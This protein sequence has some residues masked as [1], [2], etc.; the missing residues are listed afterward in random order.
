MFKYLIFMASLLS[1]SSLLAS[2]LESEIQNI[3]QLDEQSVLE[4]LNILKSRATSVLQSA[5]RVEKS[6]VVKKG[7]HPEVIIIKDS[8][9]FNGEKLKFGDALGDW[10]K[11]ISGNPRCFDGAMISCVW[12]DLGL[13]IGTDMGRNQRVKFI[14]IYFRMFEIYEGVGKLEGKVGEEPQEAA[15]WVPR[16]IFAGYLEM[17][18]Y[19]IDAET[20]FRDIRSNIDP[21]RNL[22]C[23]LRD[24][25]HPGGALSDDATIY[26]TLDGRSEHSKLKEFSIS[27]STLHE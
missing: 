21:K 10:K 12:D 20:K 13:E 9:Y 24:C 16:G 6:R 1:S 5:R 15:Y 11:I 2:A 7:A 4:S 22:N 23:G 17:D 3:K 19:G 8:L 14:N 18:G 27:A 25:S 26:L